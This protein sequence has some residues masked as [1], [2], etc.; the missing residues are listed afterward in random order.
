MKSVRVRLHLGGLRSGDVISFRVYRVY[1]VYR[2]FRVYR[3]YRV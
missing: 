2:V 3:V 1:R